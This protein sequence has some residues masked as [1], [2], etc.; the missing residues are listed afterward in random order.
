MC[1]PLRQLD[2]TKFKLNKFGGGNSHLQK[3]SCSP[4]NTGFVNM[5]N[6]CP[7]LYTIF[8]ECIQCTKQDMHAE[9]SRQGNVREIGTKKSGLPSPLC[10]SQST[11]QKFTGH[12]LHNRIKGER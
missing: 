8:Q 10:P 5:F 1:F 12:A 3:H 6:I 11:Q 7:N 4:L 2:I 9:R